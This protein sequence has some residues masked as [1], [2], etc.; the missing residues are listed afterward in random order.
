[1]SA[2]PKFMAPEEFGNDWAFFRPVTLVRAKHM[3]DPFSIGNK[4]FEAGDYVV[5]DRDGE[6]AGVGAEEFNA[7]FMLA[8]TSVEF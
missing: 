3:T 8:P 7:D 4:R 5:I 6:V 2:H 1:M